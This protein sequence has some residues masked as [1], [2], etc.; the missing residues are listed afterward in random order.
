MAPG[1]IISGGQVNRCVLGP[2]TRIE[3]HAKVSDS[4]LFG[5]VRIG[6]GAE[7][8]RVIVDKNVTIPPGVQIGVDLDVDRQRGFEVS[9]KGVVVI[10]TIERIEDI[11]QREQRQTETVAAS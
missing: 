3:E 2:K 1:C 6:R 8:R 10:P 11:F 5:G 9:D 4:I 7:V